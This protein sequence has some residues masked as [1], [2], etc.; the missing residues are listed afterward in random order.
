MKVPH[1]G[2]LVHMLQRLV[3]RHFWGMDIHPTARIEPTA[4]IDRTWPNG[5]HIGADTYVAEEAVVLAHDFTRDLHLH[6]RIG[7][8]CYLGPRSI[9]LPGVTIGDDCLIE[10]GSLVN[11]DVPANSVAMGNP[12]QITARP[13]QS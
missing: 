4:L 8:R 5:I 3:R 9:V 6:T 10:P 7:E 1:R 12:I 13:T 2:G 11:R